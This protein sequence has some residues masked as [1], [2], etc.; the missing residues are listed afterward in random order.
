[1]TR[2]RSIDWARAGRC[3]SAKFV[4]PYRC[5]ENDHIHIVLF[6][7]AD[8]PFAQF[9]LDGP[10]LADI[11]KAAATALEDDAECSTIKAH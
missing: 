8:Q 11:N 6:D 3:K 5:A 1:M 7:E 10:L 4:H 2:P 9:V